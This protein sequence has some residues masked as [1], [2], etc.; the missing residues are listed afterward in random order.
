MTKVFMIFST[1]MCNHAISS[2]VPRECDEICKEPYDGDDIR[3]YDG[4]NECMSCPHAVESKLMCFSGSFD[5][6]RFS[7]FTFND[8]YEPEWSLQIDDESF[9]SVHTKL[10]KLVIDDDVVYDI[11]LD[12]I[13]YWFSIHEKT[14]KR[15][16]THIYG[17]HIDYDG[18]SAICRALNINPP[19]DIRTFSDVLAMYQH[20]GNKIFNVYS[21]V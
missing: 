9:S 1:I 18:I 2:G 21:N 19:C 13:L 6:V 11:A 15:I 5:T 3:P 16:L 10:Y 17:V 12:D 14:V 20:M 7:G 4:Y 8:R